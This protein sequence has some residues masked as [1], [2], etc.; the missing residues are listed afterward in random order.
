MKHLLEIDDLTSEELVDIL[1]R[2]ESRESATHAVPPGVALIFEM[3]SARTRNAA[4]MAAVQLG[5]HPV[6]I[7]AKELGFDKR[8]STE[9]IG[10]TLACYYSIVSARVHDHTVLQRLASLNAVPIVNLLSKESH[11]LQ[12]LA[13]IMTISQEFGGAE[14]I[15][16]AYVGHPGNVWLSLALASGLVGANMR[17]AVPE[18][19]MPSEDDLAR[20]KRA[21]TELTVT[22]DTKSAVAGANVVYTDK[23]VSMSDTVDPVTRR[24]DFADFSITQS[25]MG[26]AASDAIFMHCLPA[27]RGDEVTSAVLDGSSSRVWQQAKNRMHT[28]RGVFSWILDDLAS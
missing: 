9:D 17:L 18:T 14:G 10:M 7:D 21:G 2:S 28:T 6:Y 27:K 22:T 11:P 3:P 26:L 16:I 15:E 8:E 23:W 20:I 1:D 19:Q 5:A 24:I 13:D 12:A 25:M 4:E